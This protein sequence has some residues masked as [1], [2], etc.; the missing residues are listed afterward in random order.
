MAIVVEEI[1][2]VIQGLAADTVSPFPGFFTVMT[3]AK[4][5]ATRGNFTGKGAHGDPT[6]RQMQYIRDLISRRPDLFE[7]KK[8]NG[9]LFFR[10]RPVRRIT[11]I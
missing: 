7:L 6:V 11:R 1:I 5:M 10:P 2:D 9:K 3:V 8:V 4:I